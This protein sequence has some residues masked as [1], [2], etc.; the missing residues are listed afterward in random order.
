MLICVPWLHQNK[1]NFFCNL[2]EIHGVQWATM[3]NIS[4]I[5]LVEQIKK[6]DTA[7]FEQLVNRHKKYAFTLAYRI[8]KNHED[9]EEIA[10]DAFLKI[11]SKINDF[12]GDSKFSTWFYRIVVNLAIGRTRKRKIATDDIDYSPAMN[13]PQMD[14]QQA[15]DINERS[16]YIEKAIG[17]LNMDERTLITLF[18]FEE[19]SLDEM[20]EI[21]GLDKNLMKVKIFRARKKLAKTLEALLP[22]EVSSIY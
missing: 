5:H 1:N 15:M 20:E 11:H 3:N 13:H 8:L 6:G 4:D 12:K 21:T 10:H 16:Y 14:N 9:A 17:E 19:L 18:Y 22:N 2:T 7:S